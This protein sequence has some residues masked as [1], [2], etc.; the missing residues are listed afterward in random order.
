M[1]RLALGGQTLAG[2]LERGA[3]TCSVPSAVGGE[4]DW[5]GASQLMR[6]KVVLYNPETVFYTMPL[7]LLAIASCLDRQRY[8]VKIID[9]RL[10]RDPISA[11]LAQLDDALCVGVSVLTGAPIGDA[12]KILRAVKAKR[13]D[14]PTV[15]GG[16]HPSLFPRQMLEEPSIDITVQG[17]G[18]A[19]FAELLGRLD[20]GEALDGILGVSFVRE[21]EATTN[22]ARPLLPMEAFAPVDFGLIP[23]ER[24]FHLKG[25]RQLDYISSTGCPFRCAFCADPFVYN[26]GWQ[27]IGPERLAGEIDALWK[28]YRFTD[29]NF[30][31][32]TFFTYRKRIAEI[33]ERFLKLDAS[34]TWAAT[35]RADQGVRLSEDVFRLCVKSGLRRV[36]IGVESGSPEV[37]KRITKDTTVD[38]V[39]QSAEMCARADVAVIFSFIVGF[40]DEADEDVM[41]TVS[42]VKKLRAMS[43]KF[44]T[45]IFYY[46]PYPGSVLSADLGSNVPQTLDEWARFDYVQGA[47]G[48]WV[49]PAVYTFME[50]FKFYSGHAW[51]RRHPLKWPLQR[52]SRW[53]CRRNWFAVPWEKAILQKVLPEA[54]LS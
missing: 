37:L 42:L 6:R 29:L 49:S 22:P 35:M 12:L 4:T 46:K 16:W 25:L 33:A 7:G 39:L 38:Q 52:I 20:A 11:V 53:R 13:P 44:E 54:R 48:P 1:V 14:L 30:Q 50:R 28:Q 23:V 51:G 24:Y 21:G 34:F 27:A 15:C 41:K 3:R 47:A 2:P 31:D 8:D 32:E 36:L 45:P 26:R 40:P 18:E 9:G 43:P 5:S 10:E 17:Q 19:T